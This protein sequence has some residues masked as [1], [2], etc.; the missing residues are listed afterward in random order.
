MMLFLKLRLV[1]FPWKSLVKNRDN[2]WRLFRN[3]H[4][5]FHLIKYTQPEDH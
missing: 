1:F 2:L 3:N 4:D 5:L